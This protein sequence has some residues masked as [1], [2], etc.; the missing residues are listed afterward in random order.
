MTRTHVPTYELTNQQGATALLE[1]TFDF[2]KRNNVRE[3]DIVRE[4]LKN[5][6]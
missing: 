3:K 4:R 5:W 6:V 2:L 1:A